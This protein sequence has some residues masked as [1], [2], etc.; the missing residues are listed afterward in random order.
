MNQTV[1][2]K[3][4][5]GADMTAYVAFPK[6]EGRH[7]AIIIVHEAWGLNDQIKGVTNRFA[8]QGFVC[9]APHLFSRDKDLTEQAIEKAMMRMWQI[10]PEKSNDPATV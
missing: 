9:I 4:S 3:C 8:D 2:F 6:S 7:P 10:P 5:D 1:T